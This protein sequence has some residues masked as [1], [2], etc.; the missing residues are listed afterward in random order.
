MAS[1]P[2]VKL[3]L[4]SLTE[5]RIQEISNAGRETFIK[6]LTLSDSLT[7][8][9][10][11]IDFLNVDESSSTEDNQVEV[12]SSK[13]W[14]GVRTHLQQALIEMNV[15]VDVMSIVQNKPNAN[16]PKEVADNPDAHR[17][18]MYDV[19]AKDADSFNPNFQILTK[20][21][22]LSSAAKILTTV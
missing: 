11:R 22:G 5:N 14:E 3:S 18:L 20:K 13:S 21:K 16:A 15:L 1:P 7:D 19:A 2:N 8:L 10:N 9:A 12:H 4:Q 6:P 17:Y